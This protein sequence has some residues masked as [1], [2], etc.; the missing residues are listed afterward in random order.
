MKEHIGFTTA[1]RTQN[2]RKARIE[3]ADDG[4]IISFNL[5]SL[6]NFHA[7][8]SVALFAEIAFQH[9]ENA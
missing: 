6:L 5:D 8:L 4:R 9:D 3:R 1:Y 2:T 7:F